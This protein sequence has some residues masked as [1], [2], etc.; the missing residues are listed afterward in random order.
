MSNIII[1]ITDAKQSFFYDLEVPCDLVIEKLIQDIVETVNGI[2]PM[3]MLNH[4]GSSLVCKRNNKHLLSNET[5]EDSGVR[6][7]DYIVII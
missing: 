4:I 3:L 7:G 6:N 5:L 1:T 2:N